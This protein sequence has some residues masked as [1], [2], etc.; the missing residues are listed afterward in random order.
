MAPLVRKAIFPVGGLG[1][2]FLPA[3]KAIPKEM[4]PVLDKPLIQYALEEALEAGIEEFIFVTGKGK[5]TIEDHFDRSFELEATLQLRQNEEALAVIRNLQLTPGRVAYI[6]QQQPRGL[7]HAIWCA[8]HLIQDEPFAVLLADDFILGEKSCLAQLMSQHATQG[9]NWAAVMSVSQEETCR[10][11]IIDVAATNGPVVSVKGL[12]EKPPLEEAPSQVAVV[13]R[14]IL[15][16]SIFAHLEASINASSDCDEEIQITDAMGQLLSSEK[17]Q[18]L[19]FEGTR[20]DC[21]NLEGM[22]AATV[23]AA[24]ARSDLRPFATS[25]L[26]Q[27]VC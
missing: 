25:F 2:R 13:G 26:Q 9:G 20:F 24:L 5:T 18:G 7:G 17:V 15:S 27:Q 8:R 19:F 4:L 16:S 21:G 12:V 22:F 11:G 14:Y 3:T 6:R 23:T 1:T 10:Y